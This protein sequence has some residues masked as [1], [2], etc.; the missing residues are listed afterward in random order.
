MCVC[1]CLDSSAHNGEWGG[2][3]VVPGY[4][5]E[6]SSSAEEEGVEGGHQSHNQNPGEVRQQRAIVEHTFVPYMQKS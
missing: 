3:Q 1:T 6:Q 2:E 5:V 4:G